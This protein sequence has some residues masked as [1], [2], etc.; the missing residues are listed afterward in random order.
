[1]PRRGSN[2]SPKDFEPRKKNPVSLGSDS[3][4][5]NDFKSFKIGDT[6]TGLEFKLNEIR[7]TAENFVTHK[8]TTEELSV[9]R[10]KGNKGGSQTEPQFIFQSPDETGNTAGLWF[11]IFG[12]LGALV[13]C[14]GSTGHFHFESDGYQTRYIGDDSSYYF[15]WNIGTLSSSTK[16]MSLEHEGE[17][18]LYSTADDGDYFSIAVGSAGATT[19]STVDD[20]ATAA[21]LTLDVDGDI[22]LDAAGSDIAFKHAGDS[23]ATFKSISAGAGSTIF[24]LLENAGGTDFFGISCERHAESSIVTSDAD[25]ADAHLT[26]NPDGELN[27]TPETEVKSDAPLK[28]KEAA[29]A[30]ADTAAYG[31]LWVKT[32]TPN[33]LY[34]TTDAGD[35][36]QLTSGTSTAGGGG[37]TSRWHC[38]VGGY[39]TN[40]TS[41]SNYYTFYRIWYDNWSN[42][43]SSPTSVNAWDAFSTFYIAPADGTVTNIRVVGYA[44]DTGATDPFKFY[45]YKATTSH[46]ATSTSLTAIANTDAIE[47]SSSSRN[48]VESKDISSGNSI[49]AGEQL[50]IFL[51]K[52]SNTGNQDLYFSIAISGEYD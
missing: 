13:R 41:T 33:Q 20:S 3:N 24:K 22:V 5:D 50:Y 32:A 47:V 34:F 4:I 29:N 48:F 19:I 27:L 26:I 37:A 28:I 39:K 42:F 40:N 52:D 51:K 31:Q 21:D 6:P 43:E 7:S 45:L 10:I 36:I 15:A 35:D 23:F 2:I 12:D 18:K 30:V 17:L 16:L 49:S 38:Q 44:Q 11:N 25:G 46:N 8:E 9:T 14:N 1:V